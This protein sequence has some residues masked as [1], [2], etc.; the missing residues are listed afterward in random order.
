LLI[1]ERI[2]DDGAEEVDLAALVDFLGKLI[3]LA[4]ISR[5]E[6]PEDGVL[7]RAVAWMAGEAAIDFHDRFAGS[8]EAVR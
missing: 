6:R 3:G 4:V 5:S 2:R 8:A 7:A 1:E